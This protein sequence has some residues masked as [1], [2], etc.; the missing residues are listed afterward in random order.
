MLSLRRLITALFVFLLN[1]GLVQ[2]SPFEMH[3]LGAVGSASAGALT[4]SA[5]D[6]HS[7]FYNPAQLLAKKRVHMGLGT[8]FIAPSLSIEQSQ[9][10][11]IYPAVLPKSNLGVHLGVSGP[12]AGVFKKKLALG[13]GLYLPLIQHSRVEALQNGSVRERKWCAMLLN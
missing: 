10:E 3:G 1:A 12:V 7:V 11:S 4:T 5:S 8:A 2:A 9:S 13:V 6:Y